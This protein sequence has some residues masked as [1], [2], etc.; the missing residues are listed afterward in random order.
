[1]RP[2]VKGGHLEVLKLKSNGCQWDPRSCSEAART[3]RLDL[4]WLKE[5][6][7][8]WDVC[9]G[10]FERQY[11]SDQVVACEWLSLE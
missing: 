1:M 11:G 7:C 2:L 8:S 9:S 6:G 10:L 3:A 5:N 4:L